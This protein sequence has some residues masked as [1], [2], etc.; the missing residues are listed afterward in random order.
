[1]SAT[2]RPTGSGRLRGRDREGALGVRLI[3]GNGS[4]TRRTTPRR[5]ARRRGGFAPALLLALP[6]LA[7]C[8][9]EDAPRLGLPLPATEDSERVV[10]LWQ[11]SWLAALAVG[12][13]VWGL[14]AW[15]VIFHRK[16]SDELPPQTRYNL[17]I[18][19]AYT[20][21]PFIMILVLFFYTVRDENEL[22]KLS[23]NPDHVVDVLGQQWSWQFAYDDADGVTVVGTPGVPPTLVLARGETVRFNLNSVDVIHS[24]WVPAFL[25]KL[26][27]IPGR[28][29][30]FEVTPSREGIY[31]GKCAELC[32]RDHAR[33]LYWVR[34]VSPEDYRQFVTDLRAA[35]D[36]ANGVVSAKNQPMRVSTESQ[37]P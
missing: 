36:A 15:A 21:V 35:G 20:V 7:G 11:G 19:V 12:A 27:V 18:E 25:F 29:N 8:A 26:D 2:G 10:S 34:V 13:L 3:S 23:A 6:V 17:P 22:L 33:M 16:R 32:G 9:S 30:S 28:T 14:I 31:T 37:Q 5:A 4:T 24:F 1:M